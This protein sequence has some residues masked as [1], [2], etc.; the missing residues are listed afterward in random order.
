MF[1]AR[2]F[3]YNPDEGVVSK[4]KLTEIFS[5]PERSF[6]LNKCALSCL[7]SLNWEFTVTITIGL[8]PHMK[9]RSTAKTK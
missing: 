4:R 5:E 6:C 2:H 9:C 1:I 8:M 3:F 7:H